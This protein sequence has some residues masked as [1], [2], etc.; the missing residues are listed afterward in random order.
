MSFLP[1]S[2]SLLEVRV[3]ESNAPLPERT[4][5]GLNVVGNIW[6]IVKTTTL[7]LSIKYITDVF[8]TVDILQKCN[9]VRL[10]HKAY[11]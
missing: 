10:K 1:Q 4:F 7:R 9:L 8:P 3:I 6:H 11:W 2:D 5:F